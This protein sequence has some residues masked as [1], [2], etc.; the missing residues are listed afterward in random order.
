VAKLGKTSGEVRKAKI[1]LH[2][3]GRKGA[4]ALGGGRE[5]K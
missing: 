1:E 3:E 4:D 2:S 5:R